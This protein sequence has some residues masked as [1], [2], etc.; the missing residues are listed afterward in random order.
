MPAIMCLPKGVLEGL[1]DF[2]NVLQYDVNKMSQHPFS[3][4]YVEQ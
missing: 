3:V 2:T 1:T 4:P